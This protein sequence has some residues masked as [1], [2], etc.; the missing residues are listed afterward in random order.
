METIIT[1]LAAKPHFAVQSP[2]GFDVFSTE[3]CATRMAAILGGVVVKLPNG[4]ECEHCK[5]AVFA[6]AMMLPDENPDGFSSEFEANELNPLVE[7]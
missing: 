2:F 3:G 4:N 1:T 6:E 5:T 7:A